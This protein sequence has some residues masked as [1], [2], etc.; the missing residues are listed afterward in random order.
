MR[1]VR[2]MS[3]LGA[4]AFAYL[5]LIPGGLVIASVDPACA[6]PECGYSTV[7]DVAL[8]I[9]YA[10]AFFAL[11]ASA[12][13]FVWLA[14]EPRSGA[15]TRRLVQTLGVTAVAAGLAMFA[16]FAIGSPLAALVLALIGIG[17]FS[18]LWRRRKEPAPPD[19]ESEQRASTNGHGPRLDRLPKV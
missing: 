3:I 15:A 14:I 17:L 2:A 11:L 4:G 8:V 13:A 7:G 16:V 9:V 5:S 18:F 1:L 6:G 12:A 19:E 10:I